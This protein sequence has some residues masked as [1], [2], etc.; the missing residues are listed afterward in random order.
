MKNLLRKF[1][2]LGCITVMSLSL[3]ACGKTEENSS[4]SDNRTSHHNDKDDDDDDDDDD[5]DIDDDDDTDVD[6]DNISEFVNTM[7]TSLTLD[8][9]YDQFL[10]NKV[11]CELEYDS[12]YLSDLISMSV[13]RFDGSVFSL[14]YA[15][16]D[17]GLDG[18]YE[19]VIE[20][21][22]EC[23]DDFIQD[24][25]FFRIENDKIYY[26]FEQFQ[27]SCSYLS[28]VQNGSLESQDYSGI[29]ST[30]TD[31]IVN[32]DG[33]V[34]PLLYVTDQTVSNA[35]I[36]LYLLPEIPSDD[37]PEESGD[38][39]NLHLIIYSPGSLDFYS[40]PDVDYIFID[41]DSYLQVYTT[42]ELNDYYSQFGWTELTDYDTFQRYDSYISNSDLS[43]DDYYSG[44]YEFAD[45]EILDPAEL[46]LN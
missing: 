7:D 25:L 46:G 20:I 38:Y 35:V 43:I 45:F 33:S 31:Y 1:A 6:N 36:P 41:N 42:P 9:L 16:I 12:L 26:I 13:D 4:D 11:T 44:K 3:F 18:N 19:L 17:A 24:Y 30:T 2:L 28:I 34:Y 27:N 21:D 8:Y 15:N 39:S 5:N 22:L 37:Y 10:H 14:S 32:A 29:G 23:E 40:N